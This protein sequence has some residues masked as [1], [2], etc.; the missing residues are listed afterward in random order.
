MSFV[1]QFIPEMYAN[2]YV[3][4]SQ[5]TR[6]LDKEIARLERIKTLV[7]NKVRVEA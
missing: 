2:R 4:A 6:L 7:K 3:H 1:F 5:L